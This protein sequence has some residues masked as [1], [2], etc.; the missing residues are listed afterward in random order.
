MARPLWAVTAKTQ[1][2]HNGSPSGGIAAKGLFDKIRAKP[3]A[4][5]VITLDMHFFDDPTNFV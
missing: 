3:L 1:S 2:E 4:K 5:S